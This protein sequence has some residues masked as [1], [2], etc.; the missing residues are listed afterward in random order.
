MIRDKKTCSRQIFGYSALS[1][2]TPLGLQILYPGAH[3]RTDLS[4]GHTEAYEKTLTLTKM[5]GR[6]R[7]VRKPGNGCTL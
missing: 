3:R 7:I 5:L 6:T 4:A 2:N 1:G